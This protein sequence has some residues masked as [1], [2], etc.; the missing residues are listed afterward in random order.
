[1]HSRFMSAS[2]EI[3]GIKQYL[4]HL[5]QN[6]CKLDESHDG[7]LY[8]TIAYDAEKKIKDANQIPK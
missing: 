6:Q 5:H 7:P 2:A 3:Q 4:T 8:S 1:M